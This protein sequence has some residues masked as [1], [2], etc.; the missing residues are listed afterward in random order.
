MGDIIYGLIIMILW[1]G[2]GLSYA[3]IDGGTEQQW[4]EAGDYGKKEKARKSWKFFFCCGFAISGFVL[5]FIEIKFNIT[6]VVAIVYNLF[7]LIFFLYDAFFKDIKR[8]NYILILQEKNMMEIVLLD[9]FKSEENNAKYATSN[10]DKTLIF[11]IIYAENGLAICRETRDKTHILVPSVEMQ[12]DE[13]QFICKQINMH[14]TYHK[15][16]PKIVKCFEDKALYK[17]VDEYVWEVFPQINPDGLEK[18]K[19]KFKRF[20]AI[21]VPVSMFLVVVTTFLLLEYFNYDVWEN[22][23]EWML[24]TS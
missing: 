24:G 3:V 6:K 20:L 1:L 15:E 14:W 19:K 4:F 16:L 12:K 2:F 18:V 22:V 9:W 8:D 7:A 11:K 10:D 17:Y 13:L 23:V 5:G 21:W